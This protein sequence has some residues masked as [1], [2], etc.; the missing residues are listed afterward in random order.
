M[1]GFAGESG[2]EKAISWSLVGAALHLT[3]EAIFFFFLVSK[4]SNI[5]T[6]CVA[7]REHEGIHKLMCPPTF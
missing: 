6:I 4:W 3:S 7:W 2:K 5:I 1:H